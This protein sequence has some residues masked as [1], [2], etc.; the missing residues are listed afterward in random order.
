MEDIIENDEEL[1]EDTLHDNNNISLLIHI[2]L[3]LKIFKLA[4]II[5]VVSY[6]IGLSFWIFSDISEEIS[7]F[8]ADVEEERIEFFLKHEHHEFLKG[9]FD[10]TPATH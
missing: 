3:Y 8:I 5:L 1:A 4:I 10:D 2:N 9:G 7:R 6:F